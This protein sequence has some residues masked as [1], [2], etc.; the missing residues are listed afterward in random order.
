MKGLKSMLMAEQTRLE[1]IVSGMK[2]E[3]LD[4]PEG[5]LRLSRSKN[6]C[7]YYHCTQ[8]KKR[9]SYIEKSNEKLV[10][11][12][13]QKAYDQKVLKLAEKRLLQINKILKDYEDDEIEKIYLNEHIERKKRI[14]PVETTWE[15]KMNVW[16]TKEYIGKD[17]PDGMPVIR[18]E[19]GERVR[20]KSEKIMA[21]YFYRNGIEYKYECPIYLK[22]IGVVYP[23]FT[24][25]SQKTGEEIYWEH[26]GRMDDPAYARN[27]VRK[28]NAYENNNIYPGERLIITYETSQMILNTDKIE[29]LVEKYLK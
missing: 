7:Q 13:A 22:G 2:V 15:D 24:F 9:G 19:K 11:D 5:T 10:K 18:T 1:R 12:L 28:I 29:K 20:S 27:A 21:D 4:V 6:Y 16:K 3:L 14:Q 26:H 17:F 23:D 25:L 8:D